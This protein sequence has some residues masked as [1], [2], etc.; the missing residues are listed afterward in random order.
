[1]KN[2]KL[3]FLPIL[4][5]SLMIVSCQKGNTGAA[6]A[7]G[8]TGATGATGAAGA[9]GTDSILYSAPIRL[10]MNLDED[11]ANNNYAYTDSIA[12]PALTQA[13][14][15]QDII[16]GYLYVPFGGAGDS[17]WVSV[18]ND[19]NQ[20]AE[21]FPSVGLIRVESY[22]TDFTTPDGNN[23][24]LTGIQFK[25]FIVPPSVLATSS[26]LTT[27][28]SLKK[29]SYGQAMTVLGIKPSATGNIGT[30]KTIQ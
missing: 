2:L 21:I 29:L 27:A 14:I 5:G 11:T 26:Q 9:A 10:V 18:D 25:Y 7:A 20:E 3:L 22:W 6:G 28:A 16:L 23:G 4:A 17:A 19:A 1:M 30:A 13:V 8:A 24:D 12:T 15:N